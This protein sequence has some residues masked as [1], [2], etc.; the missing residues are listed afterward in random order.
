[1]LKIMEESHSS[2]IYKTI[3]SNYSNFHLQIYTH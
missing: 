2:I 3:P 1:M